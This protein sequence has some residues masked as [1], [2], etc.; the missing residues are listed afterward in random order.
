MVTVGLGCLSRSFAE[1]A[2]SLRAALET[3]RETFLVLRPRACLSSIKASLANRTP[4]ELPA[5]RQF[6]DASS[7]DSTFRY[8]LLRDARLRFRW[9]TRRFARTTVL[10]TDGPRWPSRTCLVR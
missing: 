9:M 1:S 7:H 3:T 5:M 6:S 4:A 2:V 8:E 10:M